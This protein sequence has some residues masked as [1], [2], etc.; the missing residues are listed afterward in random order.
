MTDVRAGSSSAAQTRGCSSPA[1]PITRSPTTSSAQRP[2][3]HGARSPA[4]T[5]ELDARGGGDEPGG[6]HRVGPAR[7]AARPPPAARLAV[8]GQRDGHVP[9]L[10]RDGAEERGQRLVVRTALDAGQ[11]R[12]RAVAAGEH[13]AV[14]EQRQVALAAGEV[15]GQRGEQAGQQRRPQRPA[16]PPTAGSARRR[17][18]RRGSSS[19]QA[20]GVQRRRPDE[21]VGRRLDVPGLGQRPAHAAPAALHVGE[22]AARRGRRA[23][24]TGCRRTRRAGRPPRP[25]RPGRSG[26]G[27]R[28]AA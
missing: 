18:A 25:G 6:L 26:R 17:P 10:L 27:A 28:T 12:R 16:P 15:A 3:C 22:P 14:L 24:P 2:G 23:A 4:R 13:R 11:R 1:C 20:Q 9:R 19:A 5:V 8:A 7:R 21:G